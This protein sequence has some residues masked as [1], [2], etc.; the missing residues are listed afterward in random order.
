MVTR[1]PTTRRPAAS[2]ALSAFGRTRGPPSASGRA[3]ERVEPGAELGRV[4]RGSRAGPA[5]DAVSGEVDVEPGARGLDLCPQGPAGVGHDGEEPEAGPVVG[6]GG[7]EVRRGQL[8]RPGLVVV[9][10]PAGVAQLESGVPVAAVLPV[11]EAEVPAVVDDVLGHQ[12][13]VT[14]NGG[15]RAPGEA[16]LDPGEDREALAIAG[17][18]GDAEA[19]GRLPV[20]ADEPEHVEVAAKGRAGMKR[21]ERPG[22]PHRHARPTEVLRREYAPLDELR[23]ERAE[24]G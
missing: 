18:K 4:E 9:E 16:G 6:R 1:A 14:R 19:L 10:L 15:E 23:D 22:Q 8:R 20:R 24:I 13:V 5:P 3:P 17:G 11:D 12:V 21:P 7:A 2:L